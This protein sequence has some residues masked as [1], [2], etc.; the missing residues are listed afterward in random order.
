MLLASSRVTRRNTLPSAECVIFGIFAGWRVGVESSSFFSYLRFGDLRRLS[1][2]LVVIALACVS[3]LEPAML[4]L[5][6]LRRV[7]SEVGSV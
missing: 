5:L 3:R 2:E 6:M 4:I 7:L 1:T